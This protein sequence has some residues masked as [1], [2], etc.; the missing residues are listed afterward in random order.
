MNTSA[1]LAI[2]MCIMH[3]A[4]E[5]VLAGHPDKICDQIADAIVDEF[6]RRDPESHVDIRVLGSH[7]MLMIGGE[8]HSKAD[9]DIGALAKKVYENIGY[10]D[11]I[12][13]FVNVEEPSEEMK[14]VTKGAMDTVIVHGYATHETRERLP[15]PLVYAHAL[16]RRID[17]LRKTDPRF[18]WLRPDGKVQI[19]MEKDRVV[20]VTILAS[21]QLSMDVRDV[22]QQL[23]E[24]VVI[25]F[26]GEEGV[27][28]YVNPIGSFTI[29]GFRADSGINGRKIAV[30]TYGGLIPHGDNTLSGKDPLKVERA[31]AYFARF[32]ARSLVEQG[33]C[34][35]ALV[36]AVYTLGRSAPICL[37]VVGMGEKSEGAKMN[38]TEFVRRSFDFRP[39][40]IVE[41]LGLRK[42]LYQQTAVYGHFG[43]EEFPWEAVE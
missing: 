16:A 1:Y 24:Q 29:I 37:D 23:L 22:Q 43:R 41:R 2:M 20:G 19:I 40:A 13:V 15:R 31:G 4:V 33:L 7:G 6:L 12:E 5:S 26:V 3:K 34:T 14:R 42:P 36:S 25:P 10:T 35:A 17:N 32:A 28:M 18:S 9:F 38:F 11:E 30:D 21:H 27:E 39:E 8:V